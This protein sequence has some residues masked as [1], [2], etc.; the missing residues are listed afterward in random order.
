MI[1]RAMPGDE[2]DV[3]TVHVRAWQIAYRTLLPDPY[4]DGLRPEDRASRYTFAASGPLAP[5]TL[6]AVMGSAIRGFATIAAARDPDAHRQGELAALYVDPD[7]W[8][9]GVGRTLIAAARA[10]L[11]ERGFRSAILWVLQGNVRADRFYRADG[12]L[13]EDAVRTA[14]VWQVAVEEVRYSR[15]L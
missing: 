15:S 1:R 4:L 11:C 13:P 2:M 7:W 8:G 5:M 9:Q 10:A 12:W 6:V 14:T 3:A